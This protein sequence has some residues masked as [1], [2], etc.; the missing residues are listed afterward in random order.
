MLDAKNIAELDQAR[1]AAV[2]FY[3]PLFWQFFT[4]LK[5]QGFDATQAMFLTSS[6]LKTI[7]ALRTE[8][9]Q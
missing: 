4:A 1:A 8:E 7:C 6:Y 9:K 2:E 3:P 5:D